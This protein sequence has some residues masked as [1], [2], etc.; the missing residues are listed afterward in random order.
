MDKL[1]KDVEKAQKIAATFF[2]GSISSIAFLILFYVSF[3]KA[4]LSYKN[5]PFPVVNQVIH[6]GDSIPFRIDKC[7]R[8]DHATSYIVTRTLHSLDGNPSLLLGS[9]NIKLEPGCI[10]VI[11]EGAKLPDTVTPGKYKLMGISEVQGVVKP[12]KI[13]W[14]TEPFVV[15]AVK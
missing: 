14:Q 10:T 4:P 9:S 5:V 6:P 13:E 7:N 12:F 11:S 1:Y 8:S 3:D 15:S 2:I